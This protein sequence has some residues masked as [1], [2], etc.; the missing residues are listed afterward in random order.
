[1]KIIPVLFGLIVSLI[2]I[3]KSSF[4]ETTGK[5]S[6]TDLLY[7][8]KFILKTTALKFEPDEVLLI[9]Q[10]SGG[11]FIV[12]TPEFRVL[13]YKM[14]GSEL[15]N[16]VVVMSPISSGAKPIA[17]LFR[18]TLDKLGYVKADS[19]LVEARDFVDLSIAVPI[20]ERI[21]KLRADYIA[22]KKQVGFK[23][24]NLE[25]LKAKAASVAKLNRLVEAQNTAS[26]L[27]R[28]LEGLKSDIS[29]ISLLLDVTGQQKNS[30]RLASIQ[31]ALSRDLRLLSEVGAGAK[32]QKG[33]LLTEAKREAA[34]RVIEKAK[35]L[36]VERL[37]EQVQEYR[38]DQYQD[39]TPTSD[40]SLY[41]QLPEL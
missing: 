27:S 22:L 14:A 7:A 6:E 12:S 20:R 9:E 17:I 1:M 31:S 25:E 41:L 8:T 19:S 11:K 2:L 16:S 30:A 23:K 4:A 5:D 34:K 28:K 38:K 3:S 39:E 13:T 18:A 32:Q 24:T 21:L 37:R 33:V 29:N 26:S 40:S 10:N 15:D 36:N 35:G